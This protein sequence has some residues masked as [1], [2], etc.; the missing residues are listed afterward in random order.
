M[1]NLKLMALIMAVGLVI[2]T[3]AQVNAEVGYLNYQK[4]LENYPAAQQAV[5]EIDAKSLELQQYMVDKE[6]QYKSL[7]TPLKKQNFEAQTATEFNAKQEALYKL[8]NSKESQILNQVQTAAKAVMVSQKLDAILSD[9]VIF[10]GGV[11]VTDL[12]IQKLK[13]Q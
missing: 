10:V 7:D 9:Q 8:R 4:V 5:K 1:K 2:S 13:G 12:I 6:K 3:G 11:D